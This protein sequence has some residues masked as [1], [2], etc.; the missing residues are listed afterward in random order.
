MTLVVLDGTA[1][2]PC[3]IGISEVGLD[4]MR[5]RLCDRGSSL[6]FVVSFVMTRNVFC[7][8]HLC[9]STGFMFDLSF[10]LL[11]VYSG[12]SGYGILVIC[13]FGTGLGAIGYVIHVLNWTGGVLRGSIS[14]FLFYCVFRIPKLRLEICPR[15]AHLL[16][17]PSAARLS[18][19]WPVALLWK[20]SNQ[21]KSNE[22][23]ILWPRP[24]F[25]N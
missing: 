23:P 18:M 21:T 13:S 1:H 3:G 9:D 11:C 7:Y 2:H 19:K 16:S 14:L 4:W 22:Q 24:L 10:F 5:S 15:S 12:V 17:L 8:L 6:L 25:T 20:I